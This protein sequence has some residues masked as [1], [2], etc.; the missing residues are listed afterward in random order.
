MILYFAATCFIWVVIREYFFVL[1]VGEVKRFVPFVVVEP[2][3][4]ELEIEADVLGL[5]MRVDILW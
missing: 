3:S 5:W 2:E 1:F 4:G